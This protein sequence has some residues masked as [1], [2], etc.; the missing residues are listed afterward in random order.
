MPFHIGI[1]ASGGGRA[2]RQAL[3]CAWQAHHLLGFF[4][5]FDWLRLL[6]RVTEHDLVTDD[7]ETAITD[8]DV[9]FDQYLTTFGHLVGQ[10][11]SLLA[12]YDNGKEGR[13]VLDVTHRYI[14]SRKGN[15]TFLLFSGLCVMRCVP[16]KDKLLIIH[17]SHPLS[18]IKL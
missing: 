11:H 7:G 2:R 9:A 6:G 8:L 15:V 18:K 1:C 3:N 12:K 14:E 10:R 13:L 17:I 4:H 5:L 16:S